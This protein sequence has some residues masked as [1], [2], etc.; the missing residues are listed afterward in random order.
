MLSDEYL[1]LG[2]SI[3]DA[4]QKTSGLQGTTVTVMARTASA[5]QQ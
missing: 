4:V 5:E 1:P 2:T 3:V